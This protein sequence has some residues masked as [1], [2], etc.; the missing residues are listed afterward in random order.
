MSI[1]TLRKPRAVAALIAA[2]CVFGATVATRASDHADSPDTSQGNLDI[3]DLYA[4]VDGGNLVLAMTVSPLLTPGEAT[5]QAAL[6]PEGIYQFNLDAQ[7][8]GVADAV[9]QVVAQGAGPDQTVTVLGPTPLN[10][11]PTPD[12]ILDGARLSGAYGGMF[13]GNGMTAF[14]GPRDDPFYVNLFGDESLTS[15]LNAAYGGA[16]GQQVGDPAEQTLAFEDPAADDLAGLN[17]IAIVISVPRSTIGDAL[18][19]AAD[20]AFF[21]WVTTGKRS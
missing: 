15:V 16:L 9:I 12:H 1:D 21:A 14:V 2:I 11:S 4:F 3:N 5:D 17:T 19:V 6:N 8:D 7:R 20:D 10:G 13:S 18:G